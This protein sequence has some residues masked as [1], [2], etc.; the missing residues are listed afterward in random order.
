MKALSILI[1]V[2]LISPLSFAERRDQGSKG[3]GGWLKKMELTE[4]Q[5]N[6][7]KSIRE[8]SKESMQKKQG[9][10]KKEKET[11]KVMIQG[12]S[13]NSAV[14]SQHKKVK[15]LKTEIMDLKFN[16]FLKI[17]SLIPPEKRKH[18]R[19]PKDKRRG[20]NSKRHKGKE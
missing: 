5:M 16:N 20:K 17:R 15:K 12:T 2:L 3:Q 7:I 11:L 19:L 14:K 13:K 8:S 1:T 6:E 18:L 9:L 10:L 4:A